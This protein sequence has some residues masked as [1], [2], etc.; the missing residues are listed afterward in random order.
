MSDKWMTIGRKTVA[1]W[2]LSA[3]IALD[4]NVV[5]LFVERA[6]PMTKEASHD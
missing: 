1:G 6:H 3:A 4:F 2:F 5:K